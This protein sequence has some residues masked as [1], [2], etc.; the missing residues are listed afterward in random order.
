MVSTAVDL[1]GG[2]LYV[3]CL[4][5]YGQGFGTWLRYLSLLAVTVDLCRARHRLIEFT[6]MVVGFCHYLLLF[7]PNMLC[8]ANYFLV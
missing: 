6:M 7:L 5:V 8:S 4:L 3:R 2:M 1:F